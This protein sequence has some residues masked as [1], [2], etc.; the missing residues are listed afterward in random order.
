[1]PEV[2]I[3]LTLG[4]LTLMRDVLELIKGMFPS[5]STY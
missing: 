4:F 5:E 3:N 1:M 2:R